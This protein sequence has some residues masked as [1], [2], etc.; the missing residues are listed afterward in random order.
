[1][2]LDGLARTISLTHNFHIDACIH[3]TAQS[4]PEKELVFHNHN[5]DR[6]SEGQGR[7]RTKFPDS[8]P[9]TFQVVLIN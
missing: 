9:S 8:D 2:K 7:A 1:M 6:F 3:K 5:P 4:D